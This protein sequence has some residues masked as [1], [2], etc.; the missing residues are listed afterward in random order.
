MPDPGLSRSDSRAL[1]SL[2]QPLSRS[3]AWIFVLVA[4]AAF[5][6]ILATVI[7]VYTPGFGITKLIDIGQEFD[8]RGIAA[9]RATPKYLLPG[10]RWGFDG[11][12]YAQ[13]ALDPLLRDPGIKTAIDNPP[14][15]ARRILL[16]WFAWLGGLG[17]PFWILNVYAALNLVFWIGFAILLVRLLRPFGWRGVAGLA[18]MLLTCGVIESMHESLTDFPAF[19]LMTLAAVIGGTR[20]AGVLALAGLARETNLLGLAGLWEYRPPWRTAAWRNLRLGL[21]ATVPMV[22]W[23]VYVAW[24]LRMTASIDGSNLDWPLRGIMAKLGELSVRAADGS[25]LG[26]RWSDALCANEAVHAGLTIVAT[27]TQ[28]VYLLTHRAWR[29]RLWQ[30]GALFIPVYL[31]IGFPAWESHFTVTRHA[32]PIT[33]AFNLLLAARP[34]RSWIAWFVLGNCFVPYG[35][36]LFLVEDARNPIVQPGYALAGDLAPPPAVTAGFTSG[37]S[38]A[39]Q[40][41]YHIWRWATHPQA[42]MALDNADPRPLA[43]ELTFTTVS[44]NPR[45]LTITARGAT[46][47]TGRLTDVPRKVQTVRFALPPGRTIVAFATPQAPVVASAWDDRAFAFLLK[48]L[49]IRLEPGPLP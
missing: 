17:R 38:D 14:Y 32:L 15:R 29:D 1:P 10:N 13:I 22:L 28:C 26:G 4:C 20:G 7:R 45:D 23:F 40:N 39:E 24:R 12:Q 21:I 5:A 8:R 35:I 42:E 47:W 48:D 9:Y 2:K 27:L 16:P 34:R 3:P 30:I 36:H 49:Q 46:L 44:V 18:A 41:R 37:W 31:C 25:L 6:A 43:A 11:Q 19:V 33:L